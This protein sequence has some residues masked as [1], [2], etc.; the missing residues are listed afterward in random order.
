MDSARKMSIG[1]SPSSSTPTFLSC[2]CPAADFQGA[3]AVDLGGH[4]HR[5]RVTVHIAYLVV[6]WSVRNV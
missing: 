1:S 2:K 6:F 5:D 3:F 4:E